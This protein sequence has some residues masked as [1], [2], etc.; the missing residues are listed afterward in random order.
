MATGSVKGIEEIT[1]SALVNLTN[2]EYSIIRCGNVVTGYVAAK[3]NSGGAFSDTTELFS[4]LPIP[5]AATQCMGMT[6]GGTDDR[7]A[8]RTIVKANG[9]LGLWYGGG[10]PNSATIATHISYICK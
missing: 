2:V 5:K 6:V 9:K 7:K 10:L 4:G 3:N 8:T 1:I